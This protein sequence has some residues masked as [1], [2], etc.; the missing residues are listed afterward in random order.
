MRLILFPRRA[1][2]KKL[3]VC[4]L[5]TI[6]PWCCQ[7][8]GQSLVPHMSLEDVSV[9]RVWVSTWRWCEDIT[10]VCATPDST[11]WEE[12]CRGPFGVPQ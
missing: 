11:E 8:R 5:A 10:D 3:V 7:W 1:C 6:F 9:T 12:L 2:G 4:L